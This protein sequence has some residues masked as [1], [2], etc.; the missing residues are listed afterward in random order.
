VT[1]AFILVFLSKLPDANNGLHDK[2]LI[3]LLHHVILKLLA[4]TASTKSS[5]KSLIMKGTPAYCLKMRGWQ[6][7]CNLSRFV[8]DEIASD[9]CEKVFGMMPEHIHGQVRYFIEIFTIQC[10]SVHPAVFGFAFLREISLRD[11]TLQHVSSLVSYVLSSI[12]SHRKN[13]ILGV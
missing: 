5:A 10:A 3:E 6:A 11:L 2:V 12:E 9:V 8:T 7:L 4:D 13:P 1:R